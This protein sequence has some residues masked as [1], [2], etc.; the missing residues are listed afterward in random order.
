MQANI[1]HKLHADGVKDFKYQI[2][3]KFG[4][5]LFGINYNREA[6]KVRNEEKCIK[7]V[8]FGRL[9]SFL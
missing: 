7:S 3:Y 4:M 9:N 1:L 5:N 8:S 2:N 6:E